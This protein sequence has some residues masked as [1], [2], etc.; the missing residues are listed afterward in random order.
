MNLNK[1]LE[2][3]RNLFSQNCEFLW[4][5]AL[6]NVSETGP[7]HRFYWPQ[8]LLLFLRIFR[9]TFCFTTFWRVK[10]LSRRVIRVCD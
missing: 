2:K 6:N 5:Q 10:I 8:S 7:E 9:P 3:F 4:Q 1:N